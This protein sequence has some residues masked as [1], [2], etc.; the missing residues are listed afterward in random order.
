[1]IFSEV[2]IQNGAKPSFD[3]VSL[4]CSGSYCHGPLDVA[5]SG[6]A[7]WNTTAAPLPL[8]CNACH[9]M[10]P[11]TPSHAGATLSSCPSC[12]RHVGSVGGV[13]TILDPTLHVNGSVDF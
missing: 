4:T 5:S 2:A 6:T 1:V 13:V 12:H 10:P 3:P 9:G 8:P 7:A 11:A